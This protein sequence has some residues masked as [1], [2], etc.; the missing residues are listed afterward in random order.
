MLIAR[1]D[2]I[3]ILFFGTPGITFPHKKLLILPAILKSMSVC[4]VPADESYLQKLVFDLYNIH[5]ILTN[6]S[7]PQMFKSGFYLQ[8]YALEQAEILR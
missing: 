2:Q 7:Q 5:E 3:R 1:V 4:K 8:S 6:N